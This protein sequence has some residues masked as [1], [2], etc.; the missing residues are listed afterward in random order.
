MR[1][2]RGAAHSNMTIKHLND[3]QS[4]LAADMSTDLAGGD[5]DEAESDELGD[6][7]MR[8]ER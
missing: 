2:H 8:A 5:F 1:S 3:R 6:E 4:T 7:A